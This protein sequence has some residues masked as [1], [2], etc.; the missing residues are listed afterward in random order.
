MG[1]HPKAAVSE[2]SFEEFVYRQHL[3]EV[4]LLLDFISGR[5]DKRLSDLDNKISDPHS[6]N[7]H[8]MSSAEIVARVTKMRH[9]PDPHARE[10][11]ADAAFLLELKDRLNWLAYPARGLTIAYTTMFAEGGHTSANTIWNA[12]TGKVGRQPSATAEPTR[13]EMAQ[14][15]FPGLV[16]IAG[17]FRLM[18]SLISVGGLVLSLVSAVLLWEATYGVRLA[19]HFAQARQA[20]NEMIAKLYD[21]L[22]KDRVVPMANQPGDLDSFCGIEDRESSAANARPRIV[23]KAMDLATR[24]VSTAQF[25]DFTTQPNGM[26]S[27]ARQVSTA[28]FADSTRQ[29]TGMTS[30]TRQLCNDYAYR[31][32]LLDVAIDDL[33]KYR[34]SPAFIL[35]STFLPIHDGCAATG[36]VNSAQQED[37]PSVATMLTMMTTYLLPMLFGVVGAIAAL[38]RGIHQRVNESTLAPRDLALSLFRLSLGM[39]AGISVGLFFS[40]ESNLA[41]TGG[42][43][44]ALTLSASGIAFLAGYGAEGFFRALDTLVI[45]LFNLDRGEAHSSLK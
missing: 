42:A 13:V 15:A 7:K 31:H 14:L 12:V 44:G 39:V 3:N 37:A 25:A 28:Q 19:V 35:S 32:A 26:D 18:K 27:A 22:E 9:P 36:C 10:R 8:P 11:A 1:G 30:E 43:I 33:A 45:H 17:H 4:Y 16:A 24:Q 2:T 40:P 21:Q 5:P 6:R 41:Q 38:L 20:E 29:R 23:T 34:V